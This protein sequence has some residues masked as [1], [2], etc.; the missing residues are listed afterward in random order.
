MKEH[1]CRKSLLSPVLFPAGIYAH[2]YAENG[3]SPE[4]V[5]CIRAGSKH[6][7][8]AVPIVA[9]TIQRYER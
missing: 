7:A 6:G 8:A 2:P 1:F 4:A 5:R 3:H 9:V